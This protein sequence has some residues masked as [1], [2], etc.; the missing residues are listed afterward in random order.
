MAPGAK[1]REEIYQAFDEIYPVLLQFKKNDV[2]ANPP[3]QKAAPG[4]AP[5]VGFRMLTLH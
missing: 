3:P 4:L 1:K 2:K 5:L